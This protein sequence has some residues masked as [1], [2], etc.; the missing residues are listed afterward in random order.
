MDKKGNILII[1]TG[2]TIGMIEAEDGSGLIPFNFSR[3]ELQVPELKKLKTNI[4]IMSFEEPIDSSNMTPKIWAILAKMIFDNYYSHDGFVIL[5]GSDTMAFTASALS[6]MLQGLQKPVIF[7]GSQLPIDSIRT[8]GKENLI[9]ALQ[10]ASLQK[11]NSPLIKEVAIYFEDNLYRGNR[12][13]KINAEDFEAFE[14]FN[15]PKLAEIGVRIKINESVLYNSLQ[16]SLVLNTK[17]SDN[18]LILKLFP[19]INQKTIRHILNTP[20][21]KGVILETYGAGNTSNQKWFLDELKTAINNGI[22]IIN[23]SQCLGGMVEQGLYETSLGL[24]NSGVIGG[25]DITTEAAI[26]KLM[27]LIAMD[28]KP[29]DIKEQFTIPIAGEM[30]PKTSLSFKN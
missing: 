2:G 11:N 26:C 6:F 8:D 16:A 5:H 13:S 29:V 7:T 3:L 15:Y 1:Y 19:G 17:L 25:G 24:I 9:A 20:Q 27:Y 4:E 12:T 10:V 18:V 28:L 30:T 14:S 21:L 22:V 23:V